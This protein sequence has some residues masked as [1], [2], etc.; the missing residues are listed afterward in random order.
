MKLPV[1]LR[2]LVARPLLPA[3]AVVT[4]ALGLGVNSAIFSLTREVLL[5]PLPYRDVDRLV[6]ITESSFTL[7]RTGAAVAP[8]N[9]AA[10]RDGA[11]AFEQTAAFRRV[12]F[13]AAT[14]RIAL[15]VEGFLVAPGFFAMLG[16]EPALGRQFTAGDAMPGGDSVV[17]LTDGF[18]RRLFGDESQVVGRILEVDGTPC[19]I[20]GIL[21]STFRIYRVLNRELD[22]FR[23][24]VLDQTDREQSLNVYA[25]LTAGTSIERAHSQLATL[26]AN[27]PGTNHLWSADV[28]SLSTAF[29]AN[30]RPILLVLEWAAA[31][32]LLIAC[33]NVANLLLAIAATRR[34]EFA[35]R[36]ALGASRWRV[37]RD[38]AGESVLLA[39][40]GGLLALLLASWVVDI[41]NSVVTFQ[42]VN[43]LQPFRVDG[44]VLVFTGGLTLAVALAFT[45]LPAGIAQNVDVATTLK[46]SAQN[47]TAGVSNRRLRNAL[48]VGEL[49][50]SIVLAT[51]ALALTRSALALQ[52]L[53][54]GIRTERITT[55]Q[56]SLNGPRYAESDRLVRAAS[57]ML[58]GLRTSAGVESAALV[59]YPPLALIRVGV[60]VSIEGDQPAGPD[61]RPVARYWV[62]A[63]GYF[64]TVG[65]P[66][67]AGRDFSRDDDATR[68]G[69]AIVSVTFAR[70]FWNTADVVGRRVRA[71]FPESNAFWI[72]RGSHDWLTIVGVVADVR[73]DGL[74]DSAGFPQLYLTYAQNPTVVVTLMARDHAG[75]HDAAAQALRD[76]V[77]SVDPQAPVSYEMRM[78]DVVNET[79]ARP[80]EMAW[81]IGAF[82]AL[83]L[84][85]S[86]I[87]VYGLMAFL[88]AMRT[89]EIGVRVALG[90]APFDIVRL[91]VGYALK[92]TGIGVAIGAAL[93]PIA[94]RLT[95]GLLFGV[96]VVD[97]GTLLVVAALLGGVSIGAAAVPAIR[98]ARLAS[99]SLH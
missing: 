86:A 56:V 90:A 82:A 96:G 84:V 39:V 50:L 64:D 83:A 27:L 42:D 17:L 23:P 66:I 18:R 77:R 69:V 87:G 5:K 61:H 51:S 35:V 45:L 76:V 41:L 68:G 97:P 49:A 57:R 73:E 33:A 62:A 72:P 28:M 22:L 65:I 10:W 29:A 37:A 19:T 59:N 25:K 11:D 7:G 3:V 63:P 1:A 20:V 24:L 99:V 32:V 43:R 53:P 80:R 94:L 52:A 38:L 74:P 2:S 85:L 67:L 54:R 34:K 13:N 44:W 15:Q 55:A 60:P 16:V 91:V 6:R 98:A 47:L 58:E 92:L 95:A 88:T 71:E 36:H 48:I 81:I 46:E 31:L 12:Q 78:D 75:S 30:A 40:A 14:N 8:V 26:Y 70:R 93:S 89:H 4:L 79:F 21:P 9:Y